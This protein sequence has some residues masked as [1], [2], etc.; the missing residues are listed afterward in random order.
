VEK[1]IKRFR[2]TQRTYQN[3]GSYQYPERGS[4]IDFAN[5]SDC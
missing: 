1:K 2:E 3:E 4:T 5:W